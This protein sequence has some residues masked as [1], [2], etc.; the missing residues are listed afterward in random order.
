[1]SGDEDKVKPLVT[2]QQ[3]S[4][5]SLHFHSYLLRSQD[6]NCSSKTYVGFTV[7][8]HRRLRQ[9]NGVIKHGGARK[10]KKLGRPWEYAVI[11]YGFCTQKVAL[12]FEW[13]WQH[14][15]RSLAVR[16]AIGIEEAK[17]IKRKRAVQGQL[18]VLKS[19][20]SHCPDLYGRCSLTLYFF[21]NT[22][23]TMYDNIPV[24]RAE[25]SP[26]IH[27]EVVASLEEM[28][29]FPHFQKSKN[30]T[31]KEGILDQANPSLAIGVA[32]RH[33]ANDDASVDNDLSDSS[34]SC[35]VLECVVLDSDSDSS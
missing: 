27:I 31:V 29:F 14:C 34:D 30:P 5:N 4:T 23:K 26:I 35:A 18:W 9:H 15:D 22:V 12:Q 3:S 6:P 17:K 33:R 2:P 32:G 21:H 20:V 10:T 8:P 7:N 13:A 16:G 11:V 19:I 1:M 25:G 28:P 24:E